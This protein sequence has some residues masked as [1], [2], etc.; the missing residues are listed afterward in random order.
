MPGLAR[1]PRRR[2]SSRSQTRRA[3]R[4]GGCTR[5]S[6]GALVRQRP[7]AAWRAR[8]LDFVDIS[9]PPA[10]HASARAPGARGL[11][12]VLCEKPLGLL[13][14]GAARL[15]AL[16]A[17]RIAPSTASTTGSTPRSRCRLWTGARPLWTRS[18]R[19]GDAAAEPARPAAV[20]RPARPGN[21]RV[22]PRAVPAAG[23]SSITGGTPFYVVPGWIKGGPRLV[24]G[25]PGDPKAPRVA[26]R[27]HGE[28]DARVRRRSTAEIVSR[29]RRQERAN[30]I[31]LE[32]T[33]GQCAVDGGLA[34][35]ATGTPAA[36]Q[37]W[38]LQ[39]L[40]EGSRHPDW[41][42]GVAGAFRGEAPT[43]EAAG[44]EPRAKPRCAS[45]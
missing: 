22:G 12:H 38:S 8:R 3:E 37:E 29:G 45:P 30:G 25:A 9:T 7:R 24:A 1:T 41:F 11:L 43:L 32:G 10:S 27:G 5:T 16:A 4:R 18:G 23:S 26:R 6:P 31:E 42:A 17:G 20:G 40:A 34:S 35:R 44:P 36:E 13:A 39:S 33:R 19:C 15:P 14:G 21:W 28:R 2:R